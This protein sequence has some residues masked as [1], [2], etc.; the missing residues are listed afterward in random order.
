VLLA[1]NRLLRPGGS[2]IFTVPTEAFSR[3]LFL[4]FPGYARRRNRQ[5][6]HINLW[7]LSQWNDC[8]EQAGFEVELVRPYLRP[9]LVRLWDLLELLQ[10]IYI[11]R[12]RL[13]KRIWRRMTPETFKRMAAYGAG[14]DLS[15]FPP[16]GGR[17]I[18]AHKAESC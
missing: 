18:S 17:L 13:V 12:E 3:W 5:F 9:S 16:G 6:Q 2:L 10:E 1:A 11:A 14:L 4:P 15:A 8:L 7:P